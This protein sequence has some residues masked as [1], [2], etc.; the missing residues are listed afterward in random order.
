LYQ[1]KL[2]KGSGKMSWVADKVFANAD[3]FLKWLDGNFGGYIASHINENHV[4]H[5]YAPNHASYAKYATLQLHKNMRNYHVNTNHWADIAQNITVGKNGDIVTGR[6]IRLV[7]VSATGHNGNAN[8][9]PFAYEMIGNFDKGN[10]KLEGKQLES[11]IKISRYF[12]NKGKA[13]KFHRELLLPNGKV[14]K[15][16]PGTG[17]DK[18]WFMDLVKGGGVESA[19]T[20]E[21]SADGKLTRGERGPNVKQLNLWLNEL[22]YT[23]K[24]D[25]LFDQYTEA[26]LKA[27]QKDYGLPQDAVYTSPI[28]DVM[29]KAIVDMKTPVPAKPNAITLDEVPSKS[30]EKYRL[31]NFVDTDDLALIE[32]Y[33]K[34]GYKVVALPE[35]K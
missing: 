14:P 4:H 23:T 24:T 11:A 9:H 18:A 17:V 1:N 5:T 26:A 20:P 2:R 7:P 31:A 22:T 15:T 21:D 16:C 34:D 25:D 19:A 6:D 30:P 29:V 33:K 10:D 28:G 32:Q 35:G 3:D 27:F 12:Y 8:L 13:V